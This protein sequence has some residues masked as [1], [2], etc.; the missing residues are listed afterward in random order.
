ML[1]GFT[2]LGC[3]TPATDHR[4]RHSKKGHKE[5]TSQARFRRPLRSSFGPNSCDAKREQHVRAARAGLPLE[6]DSIDLHAGGLHH[7]GPFHPLGAREG[8]ELIG[9]RD[10]R[11]DPMTR[12]AAIGPPFVMMWFAGGQIVKTATMR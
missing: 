3:S 4:N 9:R 6:R 1:H 10:H 2:L 12:R 11:L 8:R 7:L 5:L